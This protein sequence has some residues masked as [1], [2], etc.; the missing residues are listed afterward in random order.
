MPQH[1]SIHFMSA[2]KA[3]SKKSKIRFTLQTTTAFGLKLISRLERRAGD[4]LQ[5]SGISK[6]DT[7]KLLDKVKLEMM[8]KLNHPAQGSRVHFILNYFYYQHYLQTYS[9]NFF[10][11]L[12]PSNHFKRKEQEINLKC[13]NLL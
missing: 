6:Y 10:Q 4:P 8:A 5:S 2:C 3:R 9:C 1:Q 11:I 12:A 13:N 7:L